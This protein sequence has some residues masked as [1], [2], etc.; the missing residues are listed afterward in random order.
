MQWCECGEWSGVPCAWMGPNSELVRV[1]WVPHW[2][3]DSAKAAGSNRGFWVPLSVHPDCAE[4]MRYEWE[5]GE[6]T[7]R[8]DPFVRVD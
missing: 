7:D 4:R 5:D 2:Q 1:R 3:R 8:Q 6:Q